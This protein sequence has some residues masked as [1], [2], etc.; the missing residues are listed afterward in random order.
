MTTP[1][2]ANR[3]FIQCSPAMFRKT[4]TIGLACR[5]FHSSSKRSSSKI[6][7]IKRPAYVAIG[8]GTLYFVDQQ[9]NASCIWRTGRTF[10]TGALIALDYKINFQARPPF[11][12]SI[13]ALHERNSNVIYNLLRANGG[14]YLKIG[15][16]MAMQSAIMPPEFQKQFSRMFDD[17]PQNDW[18]DVEKVIREEFEGR[19]PEEVFGTIERS[20]RASASVAQVHWARLED[21]REVAV[22]IQKREI[23]QQVKWDL[24]AF[25]AV[26]YIYTKFFDLPLYPMVPY[27]NQRLLLETDFRNEADNA[28]LTAAYVE[29]EPRLRGRVYIPKVH[30][31]LS[32]RRVMTAEWIEG[33][34]LSDKETLT[35]PWKGG[36][37]VGTPGCDGTSLD[38]KPERSWWR[39]PD[40]TGGLGLRLADVMQTTVDLFS[41][42][43]FLWGHVHCDPH[44]GNILVRRRRSGAPQ[45][46]LIDHGLYVR[47][48][49]D[50]RREY[51]TFWKSLLALDNAALQRIAAQWGVRNT[52]AFASATLMRPYA[53]GDRSTERSLSGE[54]EGAD[55]AERAFAMQQRMRAGLRDILGDDRLWPRE[56]LFLGRTIR[57][58]Q[59]NNQFLGSP[60]NRVKI[61]GTWASRALVDDPGLSLFERWRNWWRHLVFRV[62][63]LS[64][65]A[66]FYT[67]RLRQVLGLGE[68]MESDMEKAMRQMAKHTFGVELNHDLFDG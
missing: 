12:D 41:A 36:K 22:K 58:M 55:E 16:A 62:V 39:G 2:V 42:Q 18:A 53:G 6:Q 13:A 37:G 28:E 20:A 44:P 24:W 23:A 56:L 49:P 35:A 31:G 19:S 11:A 66:V 45:L 33:I 21:G 64:S 40:G 52:D 68:G 47:L 59:A 34:R 63:L 61:M 3:W 60:V 9:F 10:L 57:I 1:V 29:A 8:I 27:I 43:I 30:R 7:W 17:A 32:T 15:Q 14:L 4:R 67:S 54:L 48:A 5:S 50:F 26:M 46:V 38:F 65:D 25:G 51:A